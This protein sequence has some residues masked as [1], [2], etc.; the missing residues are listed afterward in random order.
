[1]SSFRP[2]SLA[3]AKEHAARRAA[4][5]ASKPPK[6]KTKPKKKRVKLSTLKRKAWVQFSIFIRARG[7][8]SQGMQTCFTCDV[9]K[10]WRE[11][12]AGHL[13]PGRTNAVLFDERSVRPQCRRCN[14]HFRGNVIVFYPKMV[15]LLGQDIVD[16]IVAQRDVTH[17]W[18]PGEL[19]ALFEK[20][21]A[22]NAAN[23][24]VNLSSS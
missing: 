15:R 10:F 14:G 24:I 9:V 16:E 12:E 23:P 21:S 11:F 20:Y 18:E 17:K 4:K 3:E 8:D 5:R 6:K 13:V 7:A 19:Q 2:T 22:L 1:M